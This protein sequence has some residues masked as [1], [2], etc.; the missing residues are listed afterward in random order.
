MEYSPTIIC[1]IVLASI[2][3]LTGIIAIFTSKNKNQGCENYVKSKNIYVLDTTISN[4]EDNFDENYKQ[5]DQYVGNHTYNNDFTDIEL[6]IDSWNKLANHIMNIYTLY[7]AFV[8]IIDKDKL[9]YTAC[10]L[11]FIMENL[12][13][14]IVFI[15]NN[16]SNTLYMISGIT[17][18]EVSIL[19]NGLFFRATRT[20]ISNK[21]LTSTYTALTEKTCFPKPKEFISNL[22][23]NPDL[24]VPIFNE[25]TNIVEYITQNILGQNDSAVHGIMIKS[26]FIS[27]D[28]RFIALLKK[29]ISKGIVI[30]MTT[31]NPNIKDIDFKFIEAG[32]L[33]GC[34]MSPYSAYTKLL[35]CLS[36]I[37]DRKIIGQVMDINLRGELVS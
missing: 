32:V 10:A 1:T 20:S 17:I 29:T 33:N 27:L 8:I 34:H 3:I 26:E 22:Y 31:E 7:D 11:S 28:P 12:S 35:F 23:M 14:P 21:K 37:K 4:I 5:I 19:S 30:V 18:P 16:L 15:N 36:N 9:L 6:S 13:K 2:W 24:I 25:N